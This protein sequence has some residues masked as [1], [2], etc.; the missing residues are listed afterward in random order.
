MAI[1]QGVIQNA[2]GTSGVLSNACLAGSLDK[3]LRNFFIQ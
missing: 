3:C 1:G 2:M